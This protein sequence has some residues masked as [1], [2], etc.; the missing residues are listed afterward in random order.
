MHKGHEE[1]SLM[2]AQDRSVHRR[3][4]ETHRVTYLMRIKL[5]LYRIWVI[6][7]ETLSIRTHGEIKSD[8]TCGV[9]LAYTVYIE[10]L[11]PHVA[12]ACFY[13]RLC[14]FVVVHLRVWKMDASNWVPCDSIRDVINDDK[15]RFPAN[16]HNDIRFETSPSKIRRF[17]V[18]LIEQEQLARRRIRKDAN[19]VDSST[20]R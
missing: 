18:V 7:E 12:Y 10:K 15:M 6:S 3:I 19:R 17:G 16:P 2:V 4:D 13:S 5:Q 20:G 14:H 8:S 11:S 9:V 1:F